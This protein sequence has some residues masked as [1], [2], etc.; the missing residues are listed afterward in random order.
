MIRTVVRSPDVE[1]STPLSPANGPNLMETTVPWVIRLTSLESLIEAENSPMVLS[2]RSL[3][4]K[5]YCDSPRDAKTEVLVELEVD[6]VF[7]GNVFAVHLAWPER[8][9]FRRIK[10]CSLNS[11]FAEG[12][13][14]RGRNHVGTLHVSG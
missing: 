9:F 6:G 4:I 2:K 7:G 13:F 12:A 5:R 8:P 14:G 10:G 1:I 11:S 3:F